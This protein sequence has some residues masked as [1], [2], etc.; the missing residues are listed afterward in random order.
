LWCDVEEL[1][2]AVI[3]K[4]RRTRIVQAFRKLTEEQQRAALTRVPAETRQYF[5]NTLA[6]SWCIGLSG[7]LQ[8]CIFRQSTTEGSAPAL[9]RSKRCLLCD[10]TKLR[11]ACATDEGRRRV[12][13]MMER[14]NPMVQ[15]VVLAHRLPK[16]FV[17]QI[18]EHGL[19]FFCNTLVPRPCRGFTN[20]EQC[21]FGA[22]GSTLSSKSGGLRLC[23]FK[24]VL[25]WDLG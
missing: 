18:Y 14:M 3:D 19:E 9:P 4:K 24:T 6:A 11:A 12:A 20:G 13:T 21:C 5:E 16:E 17:D 15:D 8:S 2:T 22:D 7:G 23:N 25:L 10:G 1:S